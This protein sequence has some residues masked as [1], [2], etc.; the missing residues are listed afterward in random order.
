MFGCSAIDW[1]VPN[2]S[3]PRAGAAEMKSA[4]PTC[5]HSSRSRGE[6][7]LRPEICARDE[8]P[9][10]LIRGESLEV[11]LKS[12]YTGFL[13]DPALT[14][15]CPAGVNRGGENFNGDLRELPSQLRESKLFISLAQVLVPSLA[16]PRLVEQVTGTTHRY[17][18]QVARVR[19]PLWHVC[20]A[21]SHHT[22]SLTQ[23]G[24]VPPSSS[25]KFLWGGR[26]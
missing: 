12:C 19:F 17:R 11:G 7:R 6:L 14:I 25:S 4:P 20:H 9:R 8:V 2:C 1:I 13:E 10:L 5:G 21:S 22:Q 15:E 18:P 23:P 26:R 16:S 3:K 24:V